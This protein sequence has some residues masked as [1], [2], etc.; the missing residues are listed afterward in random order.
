MSVCMAHTPNKNF[1]DGQFYTALIL[2]SEEN[3]DKTLKGAL[4]KDRPF[5]GAPR[6]S[7]H[8][9]SPACNNGASEEN[10]E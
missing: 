5:I 1:C 4:V 9:K 2:Y 10:Y 7:P 6:I 3:H 8:K